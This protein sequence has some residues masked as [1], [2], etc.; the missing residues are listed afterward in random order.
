MSTGPLAGIRVVE[1]AG[2]GPGPFCAMLLADMGADVVRIGR[3]GQGSGFPAPYDLLDRGKRTLAL[4]LKAAADV[5]TARALIERA[6]VVIEGF[7]P[8]VME[9]LR[10]G[11][12]S[13]PANPRLVY[14]R[15]TGW[16][17]DGPLAQAA[18]HDINYIAITGVLDAI[19]PAG[20]APIIPLNLL[21]DFG[22]GSLYLAMGVLAAVIA[23]RHTGAG[24]VVDAAIVDGATSLL[25]LHYALTQMG[26]WPGGRGENLLDGGAP[27]YSVY[28]TADGRYVSVGAIEPQFYAEMVARMGLDPAVLPEQH[29]N[30]RWPELRDRLAAAFRDRTRDEWCAVLE[31]TD[32]CFAPVLC[33]QE[34][35][36]P[37]H[38]VHRANVLTGEGVARPAPAPRFAGSGSGGARPDAEDIEAIL[39]RWT[40]A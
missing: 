10:L 28:E 1:M 16:G 29:D 39:A 38:N 23:A 5:T 31:G 14:G 30:A 6:D 7:R 19:G 4:D 22:G 25:T 8:G 20:G 2:I 35:R 24:Q 3:V 32:A 34:A 21:G 13:F 12:D 33:L 26:R 18:G 27:F 11:P 17:Q 15:M 9:K 37:P 36:A 40:T